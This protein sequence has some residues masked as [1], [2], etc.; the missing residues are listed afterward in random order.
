MSTINPKS[1]SY[2]KSKTKRNEK[3]Q[4]SNKKQK[5]KKNFIYSENENESDSMRSLKEEQEK[6]D[7]LSRW[8]K[9]DNS[10]SQLTQGFL[11]YI[12]KK[13]RVRISINEMVE[14]LK[15]KKRRIYDITNVLQGI[16]YL[17]KIGKNE[18]L[19]IKNSNSI[20]IPNCNNSSKDEVT[21]E[22]H[23][24]NYSELKKELDELKS[25]K[26]KIE[27]N[28]DKYREEFKLISEK[29]E[30]PKYGYITFDDICD[31]SINEKVNFM[32]VKAQKGTLINVID[33]KKKKKAFN[34]IKT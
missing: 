26:N 10:L 3:A 15:V 20:T 25:Q 9:M 31:L 11:D 16:G 29:N 2:L 28:L 17:D 14:D 13:G 6:D 19:W 21:S 33:E 23:I 8:T 1:K 27:A 22:N 12:K 18:I 4:E 30:F 34:K 7:D 24:S 32:L 5:Q